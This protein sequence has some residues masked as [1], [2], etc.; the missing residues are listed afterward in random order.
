MIM[1]PWER[2]IVALDVDTRKQALSLVK[3]LKGRVGLF[4]IGSQLFTAEGPDLVREVVGQ[5]ERV[6]LDLKYHDIPNTVAKAVEAA[7]SLGVSM[8]TL[9]THGGSKMMKA[10]VESAKDSTAGPMILLGVTVLTSLGPED[11]NEVGIGSAVTEQVLRL[12]LLG[13]KAGLNGLVASPQEAASLRQSL[14]PDI[15]L[16]IPGIRPAGSDLN[17]QTRIATPASAMTSGADYL[18][19]GRPITAVPDPLVGLNRIVEELSEGNRVE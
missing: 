16:I 2:I 7:G 13:K 1:Q 10:A 6:F 15:L 18:V 12:G 8:L 14:G 4:K 3:T 11:L 19:V 9:H 17:D 5:G